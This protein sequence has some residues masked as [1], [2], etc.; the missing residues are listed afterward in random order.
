MPGQAGTARS[1]QRLLGIETGTRMTVVR[2]GRVAG[3]DRAGGGRIFLEEA[4][5]RLIV[6]HGTLVY[7]DARAV[8]ERAFALA[9]HR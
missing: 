2:P 6:A 1:P 8:V 9:S 3:P 7:E 5:T 4:I